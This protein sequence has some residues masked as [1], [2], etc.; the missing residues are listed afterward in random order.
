MVCEKPAVLNSSPN[1]NCYLAFLNK[2]V[3]LPGSL[4]FKFGL[5]RHLGWFPPPFL[6]SPLQ[7]IIYKQFLVPM[8]IPAS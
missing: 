3:G 2:R 7:K 1:A 8:P 6:H 4:I 5:N